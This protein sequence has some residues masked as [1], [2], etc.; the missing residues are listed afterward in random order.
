MAAKHAD[1]ASIERTV[2]AV[3]AAIS[4]PAGVERD[5]D[6][7]RALYLPQARLTAIR[8]DG[9]ESGTLEEYI[10][11]KRDFLVANGF[12]EGTLVNRILVYG[13]IAHVWSSYSGDWTEPDG[14]KGATR[15][16]NSFQLMRQTDDSWRVLSILWQVE[17][18]GLPLPAD[19]ETAA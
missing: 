17:M 18:P 4:G 1:H 11:S 13:D 19:M 2:D 7:M 3:Y 5:W 15:G 6:A 8:A 14:K 10:A 12:C 9:I 16:I